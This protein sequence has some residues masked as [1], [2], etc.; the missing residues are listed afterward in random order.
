MLYFCTTR[1]HDYVIN[2][3]IER[4][5]P[6]LEVDIRHLPYS[7][8]FARR[9][10][11]A[12]PFIFSDLERL[13]AYELQHLQPYWDALDACG[14]KPLNR[15]TVFMKRY[16]LLRKLHGLGINQHNIYRLNEDLSR[17]RY[18]VFLRISN[19]HRGPESGLIHDPV[20]LERELA[21]L[22]TT[23][24]PDALVVV[25][26]L[27]Y[28]STDGLYYKYSAFRIRERLFNGHLVVGKNW[29]LK[30]DEIITPEIQQKEQAF[31]RSRDLFPQIHEVFEIAGV[32]F[33]R[34]DFTIVNGR[35]Q[36]F[37]INTAPD[38]STTRTPDHPRYET[39]IQNKVDITAGLTTLSGSTTRSGSVAVPGPRLQRARLIFVYDSARFNAHQSGKSLEAA[40]SDRQG[41]LKIIKHRFVYKGWMILCDLLEPLLPLRYRS[42]VGRSNALFSSSLSISR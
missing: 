4:W 23:L 24:D 15:P 37:E 18:P 9:R 3:F 26:F 1:R 20:T 19:D 14:L 12:V 25:E 35:I 17:I 22:Q 28:Q 11:P 36:V 2:R 32:D 6:Q 31:I 7:T 30:V 10:I 5:A 21:R 16:E 38:L 42:N 39:L 33:G 40:R 41:K 34:I 8:L 13:S 27:D 29:M